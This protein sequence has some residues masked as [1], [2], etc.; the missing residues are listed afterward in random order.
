[1]ARAFPFVVANSDYA[2]RLSGF[3]TH[4]SDWIYLATDL[5]PYVLALFPGAWALRK[6]A[7]SFR[8]LW[9]GVWLPFA[10]SPFLS[11]TGD[12]YEIGSL[13][14]TQMQPWSEPSIA[15]AVRGD[16]LFLIIAEHRKGA[17]TQLWVGTLFSALVGLLWS[18][19]TYA[20][21]DQTARALREPRLTQRVTPV[22]R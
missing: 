8:G 11:L 12:A 10:F 19:M 18:G 5:G 4:G 16:D 2:G 6:A 20:L 14:V 15:E 9:V 7:N 22:V 1:M 3:D 17:E 21:A 13:L